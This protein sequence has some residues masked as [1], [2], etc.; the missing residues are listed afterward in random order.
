MAE[1]IVALLR[2]LAGSRGLMVLA[3]IHSPSSQLFA[4]FSHLLL[5]TAD[6]RLA[7]HGAVPDALAHFAALGLPLPEAYN[8]ADHFIKLV[9]RTPPKDPQAGVG[10]HGGGHRRRRQACEAERVKE[11]DSNDALVA[12]FRASPYWCGGA[13]SYRGVDA[14]RRLRGVQGQH[15]SSLA[16]FRLNLWRSSLQTARNALGFYLYGAVMAIV[17]LCFGVLYFQQVRAHAGPFGRDSRR[18]SL[19][20]SIDSSSINLHTPHTPHTPYWIAG[21]LQLAEL[22]RAALRADGRA[23]LH[24]PAHRHPPHAARLA[25]APAR[26]VPSAL[27]RP[28]TQPHQLTTLY[29][30]NPH[31]VLRR[32]QRR[33]ALPGGQGALGAPLRIR[34]HAPRHHPLLD[35]GCVPAC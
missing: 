30:P 24:V 13:P 20:P 11:K 2:R 26:C 35:D 19:P 8:P 6:G 12:A 15:A 3:T 32:R 21:R 7:F 1:A 22:R 34:A 23:P 25:H 16:L 28:H 33:G 29:N 27:P 31:R 10:G 17:G 9:V 14:H 5:L 4:Y 18:L